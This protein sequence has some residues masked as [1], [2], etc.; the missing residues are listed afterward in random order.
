MMWERWNDYTS[1][2]EREYGKRVYRIGVD[3]G[4]S[5]PHR[6]SD[7]SGGCIYCDAYGSVSVY[8]R[9]EESSFTRKSKFRDDLEVILPNPQ[10][11]EDRIASI[12]AQVERGKAYL[13]TRFPD[14]L[15]SIYFQS[16][17]NTFDTID[18]LRALYDAALDTGEYVE[19]I[20]STRPDCLTPQVI[21]L[22]AAYT[23]RV[24]KVW[25]ELGLQSGNDESLSFLNRGHTVRQY[26]ES[27]KA[28]HAAGIRISTHLILGLPEEGDEQVLR[29]AE[30]IRKTRPEAIKI[31]NLH[32]VAGTP[33]YEM[34][35]DGKVEAPEMAEHIYNTILL[36]RNIPEDIIIQR[37]V[38]DT[39]HHR[40]AAPR[41]FPDKTYFL[42]ALDRVM[43]EQGATQGDVLV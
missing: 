18:N 7:R 26:T 8:Q 40:L 34:F 27:C 39:P 5:C 16:F 19:L 35:L 28:L 23:K 37:L 29:T 15:R 12:H 38:S 41:D 33:L 36:L 1:A 2:L 10:T 42:H 9:S 4:F 32:I 31:H 6:D 22:L 13:D 30:L 20:I 21:E 3:G 25:V 43:R 14:T 24:K 17:T 11:L